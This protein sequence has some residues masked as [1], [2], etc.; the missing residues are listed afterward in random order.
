MKGDK[1]GKLVRREEFERRGIN[2]KK[3]IGK[4][5]VSV[6]L[7]LV[8][9][10]TLTMPALAA[11]TFRDVTQ[12]GNWSYRAVEYCYAKGYMS[13]VG[14]DLFQPAG[15]VERAMVA[16]VLWNKSG[17]PAPAGTGYFS[18]V[19]E[20][21]WYEDAV[22]WGKENQVVSG[23]SPTT[24]GP[25]KNVSRQDV[26]VM[27][28]NYYKM[29]LDNDG[30]SR[31]PELA[32]E[33]QM[34]VYTDY[35]K[36]SEYAKE[37][38]RWAIKSGFM[39]GTSS[40]TLSPLGRATREQLAQFLL[41]LDDILGV[42][43]N[44]E[45]PEDDE[46]EPEPPK[47]FVAPVKFN[48]T[49]AGVSV[50]GVGFN[51]QN[52][53]VAK[54][55]VANDKLFTVESASSIAKRTNAYVAVNG[56]FYNSYDS[57]NYTTYSTL[58][59]NGE[60]IRL[61]N[62]NTPYKPTFVV[63]SSGKASIEFF[64]TYQTVTITRNGEEVKVSGNDQV[65]VNLAVAQNDGTK[66]ICTRAFGTKIPGKVLHA[67]VADTNG[68]VTKVYETATDVPI[69]ESGFVLYERMQ[70]SQWDTLVASCQVGDQLNRSY[71]YEGSSTQNIM[72]ALSCG[73]TLVKNGKAYGNATTYAQEGFT[74]THVTV[75]SSA[76]MAIGV[77]QDG[78]VVI[79]NASC[80][81]SKLSQ[82]MA[83]LGCQT[84]M[85]LDGGASCALYLQGSAMVPA[86][87]LMSNMLVFSKAN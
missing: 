59:N 82:V 2:M 53:Y 41:N 5:V 49:V 9:L 48:K 14:N 57:S 75:G 3:R 81:L 11:R 46:P 38:V 42:N 72:T 31:D 64:K 16:Q 40:T 56:A 84:A 18:D 26:C 13:G 25:G 1:I 52:G 55:V 86:G 85:N 65:G 12:K 36:V 39:S 33:S 80:S 45:L 77:K 37:A 62:A 66:M 50:R 83:S 22:A 54:A 70:R 51:P 29:G 87:R 32:E 47:E 21:S 24:F 73:P 6:L 35:A 23:T 78:T 76:R 61:D 8:L 17:K 34:A 30:I 67:A 68:V 10:L 71:R 79:A 4:K 44:I 7:A 43:T 58:L 27:V 69:P 15:T 60:F 63:D 28:Y 74:D 19:P 20:G